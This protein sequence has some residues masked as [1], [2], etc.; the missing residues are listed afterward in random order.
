MVTNESWTSLGS[1][2]YGSEEEEATT[3]AVQSDG[4]GW[5]SVCDQHKDEARK[6]GFEPEQ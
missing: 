4:T 5:I 3:L 2:H 1:C 6:D